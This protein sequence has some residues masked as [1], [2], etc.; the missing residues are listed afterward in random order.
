[1]FL[2]IFT[3][4]ALLQFTGCSLVPYILYKIDVQQGNVVTQDMIEKL[5]PGM[6]KSQVRFVLGTPL[7]VDAFRDNRWDY[8]Y[9]DQE[10]GELVAQKRLTIFFE[11]ER[12][13]HFENY[14]LPLDG[15]EMFESEDLYSEQ[16]D[17]SGESEEDNNN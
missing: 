5:K 7:I 16:A 2:K 13:N 11:N 14:L 4:L 6:T 1:M 8:P 3:L 12:L 15:T 9:M 10:K 17:Q